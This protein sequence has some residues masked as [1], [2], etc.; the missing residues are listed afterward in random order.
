MI[1][2]GSIE[3]DIRFISAA[4][5]WTFSVTTAK[6]TIQ[7][8]LPARADSDEALR[9]LETK[10]SLLPG[11]QRRPL[12]QAAMALKHREPTLLIGP[13]S[14]KSHSVRLLARILNFKLFAG[15]TLEA[16]MVSKTSSLEFLP[17]A[18]SRTLPAPTRGTAIEPLGH[19]RLSLG[20]DA[21]PST[22]MEATLMALETLKNEH[23][24]WV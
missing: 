6:A 9:T 2:I 7:K 23:H 5:T 12:C 18:W 15:D 14:F 16:E 19:S 20:L 3:C 1:T 10:I 11:S 4:R 17:S 21:S 24:S 22:D 8:E 13:A